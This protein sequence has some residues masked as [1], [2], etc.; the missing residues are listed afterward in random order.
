MVFEGSHQCPETM[1]ILKDNYTSRRISETVAPSCTPPTL[2][3]HSGQTVASNHLDTEPDTVIL[4][5]RSDEAAVSSHVG[6]THDAVVD[7]GWATFRTSIDIIT[8]AASRREAPKPDV[9]FF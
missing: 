1:A 8:S 2:A 4:S 9:P 7:A 6:A 5:P 3:S